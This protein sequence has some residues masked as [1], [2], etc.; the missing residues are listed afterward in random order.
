MCNYQCE[1]HN[2]YG[3][4]ESGVLTEKTGVVESKGYQFEESRLDNINVP[5]GHG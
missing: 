2:S 5:D 3:N 1:V 4:Q